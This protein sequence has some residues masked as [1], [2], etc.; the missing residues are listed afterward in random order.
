MQANRTDWMP[1]EN[2]LLDVANL[3]IVAASAVGHP[4]VVHDA[5]ASQTVSLS[6]EFHFAPHRICNDEVAL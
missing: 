5:V 3:V 6:I 4:S 2:E 1:I